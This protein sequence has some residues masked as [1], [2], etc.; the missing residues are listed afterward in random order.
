[1]GDY[2]YNIDGL[3]KEYITISEKAR[4]VVVETAP[5]SANLADSD[6]LQKG[7]FTGTKLDPDGNPCILITKSDDTL[8]YLPLDSN[9]IL[10][11]ELYDGI[12][13]SYLYFKSVFSEQ[14]K[15]IAVLSVIM[16]ALASK[17]RL[18]N[19]PSIINVRTYSDW[20]TK[21]TPAKR[22]VDTSIYSSPK[23]G[24]NNASVF[25]GNAGVDID[26]PTTRKADRGPMV[27]SRKSDTPTEDLL[28]LMKDNI[29][30][31][32]DDEYVPKFPETDEEDAKA[33][34]KDYD[35][36]DDRYSHLYNETYPYSS[37]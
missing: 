4:Y 28:S 2:E 26:N 14:A 32:V 29:K 8:V 31:V 30:R 25:K 34:N 17:K 22:I 1:M 24:I 5:V 7:L 12:I 6:K 9:N 19:N 27:L 10:S 20:P 13:K 36:D 11:I 37:C 15:A 33:E 3:K 16:S 23:S 21:S 35:D 18:T